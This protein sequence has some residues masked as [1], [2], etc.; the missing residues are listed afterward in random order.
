MKLFPVTPIEWI[1]VVLLISLLMLALA[2]LF[3]G[4]GL[5]Q[6]RRVQASQRWPSTLGKI[7]S[8]RIV[9][10]SS[11]DG[12]RTIGA[13]VVYSYTVAGQ[14]YR[15][16]HRSIGGGGSG[17]IAGENAIIARYP[18]GSS[19]TVYYNPST[20][21]D[22][23]LERTSG[24]A[25]LMFGLC[26]MCVLFGCGMAGCAGLLAANNYYLATR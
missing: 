24:I 9:E 20:P 3:I 5:R 6:R 17:S 23:V 8:S 16:D 1:V 19:V 15:S 2:V 18:A 7:V 12:G 4:L 21:G 11:S 14:E 10:G 25:A 26:A 22:A 13:E